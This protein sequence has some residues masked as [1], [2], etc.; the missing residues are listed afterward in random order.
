MVKNIITHPLIL[1][2][3][4]SGLIHSGLMIS[5]GYPNLRNPV[6]TGVIISL[7]LF[8]YDVHKW[9]WAWIAALYLVPSA[10]YMSLL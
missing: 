9:D 5:F 7:V 8:G 1:I 4:F 10:I 2:I 3:F 6:I